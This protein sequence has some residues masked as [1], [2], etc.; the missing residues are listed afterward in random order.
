MNTLR[1]MLRWLRYGSEPKQER[2]APEGLTPKAAMEFE[3]EE[4]QRRLRGITNRAPG[5]GGGF[6]I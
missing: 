4:R 3:A 6:D 1:R 2:I 5:G